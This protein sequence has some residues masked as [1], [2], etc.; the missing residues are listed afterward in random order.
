MCCCITNYP[1]TEQLKTI[2]IYYLIVSVGRSPYGLAE[3]LWIKASHE[4]AVGLSFRA[5]V[6]S[7]GL[8]GEDP[9]PSSFTWL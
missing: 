5:M 9:I 7:E 8:I 2:S 6:S 4:V 3:C 1:K